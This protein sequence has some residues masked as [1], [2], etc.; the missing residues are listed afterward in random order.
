MAA[1]V[2]AMMRA[3]KLKQ[4]EQDQQQP[5]L[6]Q[7]TGLSQRDSVRHK[8]WKALRRKPLLERLRLEQKLAYG[9]VQLLLWGCVFLFMYYLGFDSASSESKLGIRTMLSEHFELG[10]VDGVVDLDTL[11]DFL[12]MFT[13]KSRD[14]ALDG[15]PYFPDTQ[16]MQLIEEVSLHRAKFIASLVECFLAA[17]ANL[18]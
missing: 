17:C 5:P 13:E 10:S 9:M 16:Q 18:P 14:F 3:A 2:I 8:T 4:A 6:R 1:V 7:A 15:D 12:G 11:Q